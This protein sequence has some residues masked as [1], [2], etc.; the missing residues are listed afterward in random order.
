MK[1]PNKQEFKQIAFNHSLDID[2]RH[3]LNLYK[4]VLVTEVSLASNN[5][6]KNLLDRI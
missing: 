6:L 5:P 1:T 4:K 3:F 2:F